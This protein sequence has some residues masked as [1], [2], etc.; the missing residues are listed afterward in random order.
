MPGKIFDRA[1]TGES[2]PNILQTEYEGAK[3]RLSQQQDTFKEFSREGLQMFRLLLLFVAA[4]TALFGALDPQTLVQVNDLVTSNYCTISGIEGCLMSMKW[5]SALTGS[6]LVLS[7]GMNLF[8]AGYE[9]R[10]VHNASNPEDLHRIISNDDFEEDYWRERL[11]TY[12]ERIDHNDR[13]I[14]IKES[15]LALGKVTLLISIFGI[16]S[17]IVVTMIGSPLKIRQWLTVLLVFLFPMLLSLQKAPKRY[18]DADAFR[19]YTPL[20]EVNYKS[21]PTDSEKQGDEHEE[22]DLEERAEVDETE[23]ENDV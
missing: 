11:K 2:D 19:R 23:I 21:Q 5:V 10:G 12:R 13:V 8:A 20:Y 3:E 18:A 15:L 7:A 14:W 17:V 1:N 6:F 16:T 4:P 22:K 9:A